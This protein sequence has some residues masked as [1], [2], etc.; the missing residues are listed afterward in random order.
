MLLQYFIQTFGMFFNDNFW[1]SYLKFE[2]II[3]GFLIISQFSC[4]FDEVLNFLVFL[5]NDCGSDKPLLQ[6]QDII[7]VRNVLPWNFISSNQNHKRVTQTFQ[8]IL[9][10]DW[11]ALQRVNWKCCRWF[12]FFDIVYQLEVFNILI[13]AT[14]VFKIQQQN[15]IA[16]EAEIFRLNIWMCIAKSV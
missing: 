14:S 16:L 6:S 10:V 5:R 9:S 2:L 4:S 7:L 13:I 8:I 1:W 3:G 11:L 12:L 15:S